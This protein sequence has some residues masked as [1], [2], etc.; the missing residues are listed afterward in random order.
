MN[1][2]A[3]CS[4]L[5]RSTLTSSKSIRLAL[6]KMS[7]ARDGCDSRSAYTFS[8]AIASRASSSSQV[9]GLAANKLCPCLEEKRRE[10]EREEEDRRRGEREDIRPSVRFP[11]LELSSHQ[12]SDVIGKGLI[13]HALLPNQHT[14]HN[15]TPSWYTSSI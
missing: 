1:S 2:G 8:S 11:F 3:R 15:K 12:G 4:P 10:E 6:H 13:G 7:T 9:K 5:A 14:L